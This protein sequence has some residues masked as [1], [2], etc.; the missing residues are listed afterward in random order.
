MTTILLYLLIG[1]GLAVLSGVAKGSMRRLVIGGGLGILVAFV[2]FPFSR[3][4]GFLS[5]ETVDPTLLALVPTFPLLLLIPL[6]IVATLYLALRGG[7]LVAW[8][9]VIGG[10]GIALVGLAWYAQPTQ[11]VRLAPVNGLM[12]GLAAIVLAA[13]VALLA[14]RSPR[15]RLP[16]Y[17][18]A[19]L[20]GVLTFLWLGSSGGH[21][22]LPRMAGYYKLLMPTGSETERKLVEDYNAAIPQKNAILKEIGQPTLEPITSLT[23]LKGSIPQEASEAG[24]RLLQPA[25]TQYGALALFVLAGLMLGAG[26]MGLRRPNLQEA[27]DLRAGMIFAGVVSILLPAFEA[28][29]F[30]L[31]RLVKGWPFLV[32]FF[33]KAW[34]P[35]LANPDANV[36]PLQSVL[37]EMALTIEIA[38]VGTFLAAIFAVPSSF[39]AA[40]NLTQGSALMRGVFAFMRGFYNVDRGVDTLILALIFVA[41]VGLGPFAGVL[42]MAIHSIADLGKLYSEAIENVDKGPI[43]ALE[44]TGAAGVNVLRWAILPQVLPLFVSYTLYRFEINFRVSVVLGLVGAGGIGYFIKGAMDAGNYD[45]MIIGV[46]AIV[47]VVNLIDFASS[48]LRSRL[49]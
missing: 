45:Q 49:V 12:E 43:E 29:E 4:S 31:Q 33:H 16:I 35:N 40:R 19:A 38:L 1:V 24:Y 10:G 23:D 2:A 32:G 8:A 34:P 22:Y 30:Q 6:L 42:A 20:A 5:R 39:L 17:A 26:L 48:W 13:A 15:L 47:I 37:S 14:Q 36:F 44:S 3:S 25:R 7:G 9:G 41:A 28:T 46:I 11:V 21:T 18:V 27:G